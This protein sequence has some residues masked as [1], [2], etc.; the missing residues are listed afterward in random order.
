[1]ALLFVY[2]SFPP[3]NKC[4][5]DTST[6][7][8]TV[9]AASEYKNVFACTIPS[10]VKIHPPITDPINPIRTSPMHPNP[11]PRA[12]FP[13]SHP[14]TNPSNIHH[15]NPCGITIMLLRSQAVLACCSNAIALSPNISR[16]P[17]KINCHPEPAFCAGEGPQPLRLAQQHPIFHF[18]ISIFQL[19]AGAPGNGFLPGSWVILL[20]PLRSSA[21]SASL[22][23]LFSSSFLFS[24]FYFLYSRLRFLLRHAMNRPQ[25]QHQIP[26]VYPHHFASRKHLRQQIQ[27]HP[28]IGIIK[29]RHQHQFIRNIKIRITGRQPQ[30]IKI[31]RPRHRQ[32]LHL[33]SPPILILHSL[34]SR[35]VL[36]QCRIIRV[37]P[38]LLHNRHHRRRVHESRQVVHMPVRIVPRN[39]IPQPQ[40]IRHSQILPKNRLIIFPRKSRVSFLRLAQQTLFRSQQRPFSIHV[41]RSALQHHPPSF[42]LR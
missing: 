6:T 29:R 22:R 15:K 18:L 3:K 23:Y 19:P 38:V 31:N 41:N 32:S 2:L 10:F 25:S 20:L 12:S 5:I 16:P 7:A 37:P 28:V 30:P 42:V 35:Q 21:Y 11:R 26:A 17:S 34:Q 1:F 9:A 36:L 4:A 40:H 39:P 13:A 33:Q 24:N 14:A 8:P 27:R